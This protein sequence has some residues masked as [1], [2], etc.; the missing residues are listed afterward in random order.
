MSGSPQQ[1]RTRYNQNF[2]SSIFAPLP[3][4]QGPAAV[5][6]GKRR[7][8]TTTEMFGS[9]DEKDLRGMPK[10]FAP[11]DDPSNA[12]AKKLSFLSSDVLPHSMHPACG[13]PT[14]SRKQVWVDPNEVEDEAVDTNL[15]RQM[16]LQSKLFGR[17]TPLVDQ[18]QL[19]DR[20][21][22][23]TPS[24]VKWHTQRQGVVKH[25]GS[26]EA[27]MTHTDRAYQEKCSALFDHCSPQ[28]REDYMEAEK[29]S[30]EEDEAGDLKRRANVYYSDLFGRG[31]QMDV[32]EP[33]CNGRRPKCQPSA[34]DRITIQQDWTDSRNE[35]LHRGLRS[36]RPENPALRKSEELHQAR[37]FGQRSEAWQPAEKPAPVTHDNSQKLRAALGRDPREMHQ[38]HLRSSIAPEEFYDHAENTK[39]WQVLELHI[40]GL[41]SDA[42]DNYVRNLC[43]GF[44]LQLVRATAEVDPVRNLCKGRAKV[45]V[46]YNPT[47]DD[48]SGLVQKLESSRLRVEM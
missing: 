31:A 18:N 36:P 44:D 20:S 16:D 43:H 34:E 35:L 9:Y 10:T 47:R 25:P 32:P 17:E 41:S 8:Q 6:A 37:I 40:S 26:G 13:V 12:R 42:D 14:P 39:H 22:R 4:P 29:H 48:I 15:R 27:A 1:A 11:K 28:M 7:D 21:H 2:S 45:M 19:H 46:R 5:P 3:T 38:A 23:L 24:D 33:P 30:R